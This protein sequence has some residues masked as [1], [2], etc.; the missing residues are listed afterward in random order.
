MPDAPMLFQPFQVRDLTIRNRTVVSPMCQYTAVDGVMND[1]HH[2]HLASLARGGF[3]M[4]IFEATGVEARG[5][6]THGCT[7][8]WNDEQ[9]EVMKP[10]V[11]AVKAAG[12]ATCLQIAHAGR[13]A[14]C[15]RPWEGDAALTEKEFA[16][17]EH[18]WEI[19]APSPIPFAEGWLV[20]RELSISDIAET[21][22]MWVAATGRAE[23]A[24]FEA[25]E[26]HSAHGYLSHSFLS[27]ISNKRTDKYGGSRENRMRFTL[28]L[29]EAVRAA[30]PDNKPLFIRLSTVDAKEGG[31]AIED[32][33]ALSKEL[34]V[35]GVDVVDCSSGAIA[36]AGVNTM[37]TPTPGYQVEYAAAIRAGADIPTQ[38][39]GLILS[40]S[41]AET[42][43]RSGQ[44]D[45][46][47]LAR[48]ALHDPFWPVHAAEELGADPGY[49]LWPHQYGYWLANR[50][51][52]VFAARPGELED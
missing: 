41:Q 22:D 40:A 8:L 28:E 5:R 38:A 26:I 12:A 16:N 14:S 21:I 19:V 20:P 51:R 35:R 42:I 3:G 13:K 34:K 31:W 36:E 15:Q 29:T 11:A 24:G 49:A 25:L 50:A 45:L 1:W 18:A 9:V 2:V 37:P 4:V 7:G 39:V 32:S 48:E 52:G 17:G 27:P 44:A 23:A 10:I 47:A 6:I 30:W 46:I 33:I 43:L